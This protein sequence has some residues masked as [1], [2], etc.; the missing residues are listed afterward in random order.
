MVHNTSPRKVLWP[1]F[2]LFCCFY[3]SKR[4]NHTDETKR[5]AGCEG[6][7]F[8]FSGG[9]LS[10]KLCFYGYNFILQFNAVGDDFH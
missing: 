10:S 5:A 8:N 7:R 4:I 2:L 6:V 9:P 3:A 1:N